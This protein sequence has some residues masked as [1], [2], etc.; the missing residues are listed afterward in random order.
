MSVDNFIKTTL[1]VLLLISSLVETG[2]HGKHLHLH[3]EKPIKVRKQHYRVVLNYVL[4][5]GLVEI[6]L[7]VRMR[8]LP[9]YTIMSEIMPAGIFLI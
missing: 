5:E 1:C 6:F 8:L 4:V 2:E 9:I 7:V 3:Q